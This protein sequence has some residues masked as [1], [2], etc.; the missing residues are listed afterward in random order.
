METNLGFEGE[1]AY[2]WPVILHPAVTCLP[3]GDN[4]VDKLSINLL[5][6]REPF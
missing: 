2:Y 4:Y 6:L 1:M 3:L 5:I